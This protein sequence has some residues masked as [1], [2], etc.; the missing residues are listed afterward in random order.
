[1][2]I[3]FLGN[4]QTLTY[5][6]YFSQ[7]LSI[8]Q[9]SWACPDCFSN[10]KPND[11]WPSSVPLWGKDIIDNVVV[12]GSDKKHK[13]LS[14]CDVVVCQVLQEQTSY[15]D[16]YK[17]LRKKYGKSKI[18]TISNHHENLNGMLKRE[19]FDK[20]NIR[21]SSI[22]TD[23]SNQAKMLTHNHPN[24]FAV[25]ESVK[26]IC[27]YLNIPFFDSVQYNHLLND[28]WYSNRFYYSQEDI[29]KMEE[30]RK[31]EK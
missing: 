22:Y 21:T 15:A 10:L 4:C 13:I 5:A 25:L 9:V 28:N 14:E 16:N 19:S 6:K 20:I 3:V 2:N 24:I 23:F 11:G 29:K 12:M 1:M 7:L 27:N 18:I 17:V 30:R 31:S 8:D 26:M